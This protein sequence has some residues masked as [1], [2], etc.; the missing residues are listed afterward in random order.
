M[1][2]VFSDLLTVK[3]RR[4]AEVVG[5][6]IPVLDTDFKIAESFT[7]GRFYDH[8]SKFCEHGRVNIEVLKPSQIHENIEVLK[9]S[10]IDENSTGVFP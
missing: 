4:F 8:L 6:Q 3:A 5:T 9:P 1:Q 7:I 2:K 10:R